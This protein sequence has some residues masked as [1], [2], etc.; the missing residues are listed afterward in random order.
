M[1]SKRGYFYFDTI[2]NSSKLKDS[3]I[4][5]DIRLPK[6]EKGTRIRINNINFY[7]N[8]TIPYPETKSI[9]LKLLKVMVA[10]PKLVILIEGHTNG[11]QGGIDYS[12]NLSDARAKAV[13]NYLIRSGINPLRV[14][15]IGYN[16]KKMIYPDPKNDNESKLNRR[17]E[18]KVISF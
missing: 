3:S 10:N 1:V 13:K 9:F 5:C 2:L 12:Q 7:G 11:C 6:L 8:T 16:C 17:V 18:I 4:F 14:S 15:A